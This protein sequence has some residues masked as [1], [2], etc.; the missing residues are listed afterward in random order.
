MIQ[1]LSLICLAS[2]ELQEGQAALDAAVQALRE[3]QA[4]RAVAALRRQLEVPTEAVGEARE[5]SRS[6]FS[7]VFPSFF[8]VF[9][10]NSWARAAV[11]AGMKLLASAIYLG[12]AL[13][14][15]DGFLE[16]DVRRRGHARPTFA[17]PLGPFSSF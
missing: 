17:P 5:A 6:C 11:A 4:D 12:C 2:Q 10:V 9:H 14:V 1:P 7:I 15:P 13:K 8:N 3:G 16:V